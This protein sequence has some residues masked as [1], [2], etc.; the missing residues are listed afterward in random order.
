MQINPLHPPIPREHDN[1]VTWD[2]LS[3]AAISLSIANLSESL[4]KPLIIITPDVQTAEK[5]FTELKF[6]LNNSK[7]GTEGMPDTVYFFPDRETLPYDHFSPHEDLTSERLHILSQMPYLKKGIVIAAISTLMH[8]LPPLSF[9][10]AHRFNW[11]IKDILNLSKIQKELTEAGYRHVEQVIQHGEFAVR[12]A[13]IDIFPM[14]SDIPFRIELFDNEI[15]SIRSF[16]IDTQKSIEKIESIQLLPAHEFPLTEDSITHFRQQWRAKFSGNPAESPVYQHITKAQPIG[17]IEYY[18]P[19]FYEQCATFFDYCPKNSVS[20]SVNANVNECANTFWNEVKTRYTQLNVDSTRPLCEPDNVFISVPELFSQIKNFTQ[21]KITSSAPAALPNLTVDHRKPN[22][23]EHL[24]QFISTHPGRLLIC[25][26]STGRREILL[27]LLKKNRIDIQLVDHW[28]EFLNTE[29]KIA[30]TIAPI[31]N[32]LYLPEEHITLITETQLFGHQTIPTRRS[33]KRA[34]DPDSIIRSLAELQTGAP[35]VHLDHGIGKYIGLEKIITDDIESEYVTIEYADHDRVYVPINALHVISRYTAAN[36]D[37]VVLNKLGTNNWEKA[38]QKAAKQIRDTAAELLK[39]YAERENSTGFAF[40]KPNDDYF[41]FRRAFPFEETIDQRAAIDAVIADMTKNKC[42]DRLVCGDVGFGKTEVA[43][44]AAF[45]AVMGG[46]QVAV[47]VPTTLLAN[48]HA[49]NFQD[50]FSEWPIKIGVLSRLQST[51]IQNETIQKLNE[52]KLDIIVGTHRLLNSQIKF[53]DLGL[54]IIDEEHRFGVQQKEKVKSLRAHIDILTLTATPIP[55]TLNLSMTGMR[56]LSIIATP[57]AKRLSIKTFVY[58]FDEIII[59]EAILRETMRG[60][61]VYFLHNEVETM[62]TMIEKLRDIIPEVSITFAHGQM[63][64]KM[65]EKTMS[66]FYHQRYQVL[67]ASTIIES[68]IDIPSAN[69]II[70]NNANQFGLAQLHQIRG[71]VGRSHHQA[72]AYLLVKSKKALTKDAERRLD[73]ISELEDLGVGFQLATHDLEIRGAGELLGES[74]S[75]HMEAIG[76]SLYMELLDETVKALKAGKTPPD[77]FVKDSGPDI[78]LHICALFP[79]NYIHDVHTRL[80][81]YKRLSTCENA[82]A[83][84]TMKS[85][86]IDRFGLLPE[87]AQHLFELAHIKIRAKRLGVQKIDVNKLFGY[88]QFHDKPNIDPKIIIDL[89]QKQY[90]TYQLAG[91]NTLRFKT[92]SDKPEARIQRV[93]SLLQKFE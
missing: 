35:V 62:P 15:D 84:Q 2:G 3:G 60:G 44:Q 56:D 75:G 21:I 80:T 55:R 39:I 19:L 49:Q 88:I 93:D 20:V 37:S 25:A 69:T 90:Q 45:L 65:L 18:L 48:Q 16:D 7:K 10:S 9:L 85:E 52:G 59:R 5:C 23:V 64:E 63:P 22:P 72:Y 40:P 77:T 42:M 89:I 46:K 70:I 8:R 87:P 31:T 28:E 6:F 78:E 1:L 4:G 50:R 38:K 51:K 32:A 13:I 68:G 33:K 86:V 11:K 71:R 74:Q 34:Q 73:A 47:L 54:L 83:I 67:V 17:G 81:L 26:E 58:D 82:E 36:S 66:D 43:M 92:V 12:G 79:E 91:K 27:E 76:F 14:G 29:N 30:L 41:A 57:P 61:Q 53:K 24:Q